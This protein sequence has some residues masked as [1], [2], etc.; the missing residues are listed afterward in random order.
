[1][2]WCE[3]AFPE[4]PWRQPLAMQTPQ[5]EGYVCRICVAVIGFVADRDHHMVLPTQ[6]AVLAHLAQEHPA[7]KGSPHA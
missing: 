7:Q 6:E 1:M 4:I 5:V 3:K 2:E